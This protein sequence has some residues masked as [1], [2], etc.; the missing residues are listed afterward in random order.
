MGAGAVS[1]AWD[2]GLLN[3]VDL[4]VT[5]PGFPERSLPVVETLEAGVPLWSEIEF[6]WRA[7]DDRPVV[8][9]TGTNGKTTVS[10]LAARI[11]QTS[12]VEAVDLGNIGTPLSDVV[13]MPWEVAVVEVSSFQLRF[14]DRFHPRSAA[15]LNIAADHLDW[16]GSVAAY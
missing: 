12:G 7:I 15:L 8:A 10:S 9:V 14:I 13:D 5:S 3:G 1:G 11:L 4:V 16:H 2:S 6:A